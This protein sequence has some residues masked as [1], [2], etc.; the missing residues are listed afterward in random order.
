MSRLALQV[1]LIS[2]VAS[3]A[4]CR[5]SATATKRRLEV[6]L[7]EIWWTSARRIQVRVLAHALLRFA[8]LTLVE[9]QQ[10]ALAVVMAF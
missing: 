7:V 9:E 4:L 2:A 10:P 8:A 6:K 3:L 5:R 1:T